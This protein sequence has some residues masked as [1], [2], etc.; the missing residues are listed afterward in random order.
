M[1]QAQ[2]KKHLMVFIIKYVMIASRTFMWIV[3]VCVY[4][5]CI[6]NEII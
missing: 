5:C 4:V 1:V 3:Y 6:H 2:K